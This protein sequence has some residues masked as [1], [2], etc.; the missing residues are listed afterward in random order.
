MTPDNGPS[1]ADVGL[2]RALAPPADSIPAGEPIVS[3][4]LQ[5]DGLG[6]VNLT[7]YGHGPFPTLGWV[8]PREYVTE[9]LQG[10]EGIVQARPDAPGVSLYAPPGHTPHHLRPEGEPEQEH[11]HSATCGCPSWLKTATSVS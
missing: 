10:Q 3:I 8:I 6:N 9:V 5:G 11:E 1:W 2:D 4:R 7:V